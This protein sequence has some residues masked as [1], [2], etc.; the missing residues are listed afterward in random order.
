ML[1][2]CAFG[3]ACNGKA[4]HGGKSLGPRSCREKCH[5]AA[6]GLVVAVNA[7]SGATSHCYT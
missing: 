4:A 1:L 5:C 3:S 7:V 6:L 2:I